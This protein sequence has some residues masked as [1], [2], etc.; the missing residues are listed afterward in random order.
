MNLYA[1]RFEHIDDVTVDGA[2]EL[3]ENI[4]EMC[5]R[6]SQKYKVVLL[7][8]IHCGPPQGQNKDN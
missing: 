1:W 6:Y 2:L 8:I 7:K 4:E 3:L 5:P